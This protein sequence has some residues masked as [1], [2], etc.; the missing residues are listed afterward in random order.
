MTLTTDTIDSHA[1][2]HVDATRRHDF[3]LVFDAT[4]SNP[5]GDPDG[6]NLPRTDPETGHGLVTDVCIK[7]KIRN[8]VSVQGSLLDDNDPAGERLKIYV[9]EGVALNERHKR[10]FS[11][12]GKPKSKN[13]D[14]SARAWMC[15]NFYDVRMFGAVM[16]TGDYNCGQVR[17]PVQIGFARSVDPVFAHDISITR[18][19]VTREEDL[20]KLTE[21]DGGKDR[22]MGRK[23]LIP[24]GLY[25]AFGTYS[26][27]LALRNGRRSDGTGADAADLGLLWRAMAGMWDLDV[28]AAR[29]GMATRELHVFTHQNPLG[30]APRH[31]MFERVSVSRHPEVAAPRSYADYTVTVDT[32]GLDPIVHQ[33]LA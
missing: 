4:D 31:T 16:S 14:P 9:E 25:V 21:G 18:G 19:A 5:N 1:E 33:R 7:R 12:L 29:A 13:A 10:A 27:H 11:A 17:G 28:S 30:D 6:G 23:A 22:E 8:Y 3:V 26:P 2:P 24:Y 15:D 20:Q 32:S